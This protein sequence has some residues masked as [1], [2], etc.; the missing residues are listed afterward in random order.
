M[1]QALLLLMLFISRDSFSQSF[2][3]AWMN[4]YI[5]RYYTDTGTY[6]PYVKLVD[7]RNDEKELASYNGKIVYLDIWATWCG[8]CLVNFRYQEQLLKRLEAIHLDSLVQFVNIN[9]D[10]SRSE[11]RKALNKHNPAGINLYSADTALLAK[12]NIR[13]LPAYLLLDSAGKVLGKDI[14]GPDEPGIVDYVLYAATKGIHPINAVWKHFEQRKLLENYRTTKAI[15]DQD[16]E[17]W[18]NM[19]LQ[20]MIE[21]NKWLL[22]QQKNSR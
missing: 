17:T 13:S 21:F 6:L 8:T 14:C 22:S 11:W 15:N 9:I 5:R 2:D 20:S 16:Y 4:N 7:K 19:T 3:S 18:Y 1:K 10:D 12:W